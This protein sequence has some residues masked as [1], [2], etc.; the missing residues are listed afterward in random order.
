VLVLCKTSNP[1]G[2]EWQ[3]IEIGDGA[4]KP[5]FVEL[6][7]RINRWAKDYP[8][9]IGLVFGATY[10]DQLALARERCPSLPILLPGVGAQ[11]GDVEAA[12]RNGVDATGGGLLVSASRSILY[13]GGGADFADRAREATLKLRDLANSARPS[14]SGAAA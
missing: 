14:K 4:R 9:S 11:A 12:V 3:D 8:A 2:G 1:G 7:G 6:A 10:P 13:A 5:L